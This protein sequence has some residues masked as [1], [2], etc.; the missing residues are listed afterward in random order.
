MYTIDTNDDDEFLDDEPTVPEVPPAEKGKQ[1][2]SELEKRL[3]Q[4]AHILV[5]GAIRAAQKQRTALGKPASKATKPSPEPMS[6]IQTSPDFC[7][8]GKEKA[9]FK[10]AKK[11]SK[12]TRS[13]KAAGKK[14]FRSK[15]LSRESAELGDKS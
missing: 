7:H 10:S 14:S 11:P 12:M 13:T 15:G 5:N 1:T 2:Q 6:D 8:E 3:Q 9:V 4:A